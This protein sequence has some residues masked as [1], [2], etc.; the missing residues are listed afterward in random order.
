MAATIAV[1]P[2]SA[3][4]RRHLPVRAVAVA[5]AA[6]GIVCAVAALTTTGTTRATGA[7][8]ATA[9]TVWLCRP[10]QTPDPC[11]PGLS[12]T[13]YSPQLQRLRVVHPRAVAHPKINCFYV[14]P[15]VSDQKGPF[16]NLQ[17]GPE[18]RS[19]ALQQA[20]R[21]SQ[22]CNV[23]APMYRQGTVPTLVS[24]PL[25]TAI[26]QQLTVPLTNVRQAFDDFLAHYDHGRPFVIIGH[27]Q[28]AILMTHVIAQQVDPKPALRR[29]MLSAILLGANVT[30]RAG[31][32]VGGAFA[33]I[34]AC[35]R[36]GSLHCVI[37]FSTFDEPPP[38]DTIFG[39]AGPG[40]SV[41]CVNPAALTDRSDL[42]DPIF[43]S[44]PFAPNTLTGAANAQ[45]RLTIPRPPT[46]W[47][48][49]PGA[50][51]AHCTS[52]SGPH[53]L[54]VTPRDG[55][56]SPTASPNPSWGLHLLDA[57]LVLGNLLEIVRAEGLHAT[58]ARHAA[59]SAHS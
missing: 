31:S 21:Y 8:G 5:L 39:L 9:R 12:T 52:G 6:V 28:G 16:A 37:A 50:Y 38:A 11:Q 22:Y 3:H 27:S 46:T 4:P 17:V 41:L 48:Q 2:E 36:A 13:V 15:T 49:E 7:T 44:Q 10:G 30:V 25:A 18:E 53:V 42:A 35:R 54:E 20:A 58:H 33:H 32:D 51:T 14:Y 40:S 59:Q 24:E 45:L 43:P 23:Y 47:V 56:Q 57:N 1:V 19:I 29:E 55:A 26:K 34:P